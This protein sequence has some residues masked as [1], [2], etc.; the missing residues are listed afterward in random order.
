MGGSP[1]HID[2]GASENR[3]LLQFQ[4][5]ILSIPVAKSRNK[6]TTAL[7]AARLAGLAVDY[8]HYSDFEKEDNDII[9]PEMP[10]EEVKKLYERWHKAVKSCM[11]F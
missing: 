7:G 9:D 8:Y 2:G 5:Y 6:E 10:E 3:F 4:S 1:G 11:E